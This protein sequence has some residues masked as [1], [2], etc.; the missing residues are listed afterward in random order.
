MRLEIAQGGSSFV[1]TR[2]RRLLSPDHG[3][4]TRFLSVNLNP[5]QLVFRKIR[6]FADSV[7]RAGWNACGAINAC[8]RID[9]HALII[10][11]E[12]RHRTDQNAIGEST[13]GTVS[14]NNMGHCRSSLEHHGSDRLAAR[15]GHDS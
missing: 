9:V 10:A 8:N 1:R 2:Q 14:G 7:N 5:R 15:R 12:T 6:T 4:A 11:M 13:V 3:G